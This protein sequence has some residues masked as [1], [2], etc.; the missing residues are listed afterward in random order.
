MTVGIRVMGG[1]KMRLEGEMGGREVGTLRPGVSV[2]VERTTSDMGL[3][4]CVS[5]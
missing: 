4:I 2:D 3:E 1:R 5:G